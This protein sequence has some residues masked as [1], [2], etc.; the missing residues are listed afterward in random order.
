MLCAELVPEET[1]DGITPL[2]LNREIAEVT[3]WNSHAADTT[4][5]EELWLGRSLGL[6][7]TGSDYSAGIWDG[8]PI[9]ETHDE[10]GER[11]VLQAD[12]LATLQQDPDAYSDH[13]T[14]V[15]G[16]LGAAGIDPA[17]TG[18][19]QGV[20]I[21]SF[22]YEDS[23]TEL[24]SYASTL[25]VS[26]HSY[27][28]VE[29]WH[30]WARLINDPY[31]PDDDTVV[32]IWAENRAEHNED[33]DFGKYNQAVSAEVDS[34]LSTN[35]G[36]LAVWSAGNDRDDTRFASQEL[37]DEWEGQGL[38][39]DP[40]HYAAYFTGY[41]GLVLI[42][43][44]H[45]VY[46]A[47][48]ADGA[49][50]DGYDTLGTWAT[51]KNN[52]VV[53]AV[54]DTLNDPYYTN[55]VNMSDFS[56]W[57]AT[58][59]GRIKCDVVANGVALHS[60]VAE[61]DSAYDGD[62]GIGDEHEWSGTSM[63]A[64]N[65]TGTAAL[66]IEH[67]EDL[68]GDRPL[69]ATT[70]GLLL[71]T[72]FDAGNTGPDYS[73]GWGLVDAAAAANLLTDAAGDAPSSW[74]AESTYAGTTYDW[75]L[76]SDGSGPLKATICWTDPAGD[77]QGS[78][79]DDTTSVLVNDLDLWLTGPDSTTYYPWTLDPANP[80]DAAVRTTGNHLDNVEQVLI[81]SPTAGTYTIHVGGTLDGS[82]E[83]QAYSLLVGGATE[84]INGSGG[85]DTMTLIRDSLDPDLAQ[86]S[87]TGGAT[88]SIQLPS[89]SLLYVNGLAGNDTLTVD[90]GNGD[91]LPSGG[92]DYDGGAGSDTLRIDGSASADTVSCTT[93]Q[94]TVNSSDIDHTAVESLVLALGGG[95]NAVEVE[96]GFGVEDLTILGGGSGTYTFEADDPDDTENL[97]L[98]VEADAEVTIETSLRLEAL[99]LN[100]ASL[101]TIKA[102]EDP[103]QTSR[104][105]KTN[106]L[107]IAEDQG[108]PT[109]TLDLT[110]N[111]LIVDYEEEGDNPFENIEDWIRSGL[112]LSDPLPWWDGTGITSSEAR[113][114]LQ[115]TTGLGV[116]DND[117]DEWAIGDLEDLE[118]EPVDETSILVKYTYTGD[119]N[120]DGIINSHDYDRIDSNWL[121]W[122]Y[123]GIVPD[124][125]WRWAVGDFNYDD[126]I[127]SHD[128]DLIDRAWL[129][130]QGDPETRL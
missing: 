55:D 46:P 51:A 9:R 105:I 108:D 122:K 22:D 28:S 112:N 84:A 119:A 74:V 1:F 129:I 52:L 123:H 58:D 48:D 109:A 118:G 88:Y 27:G 25:A 107:S 83:E 8:G 57:G 80:A 121:N 65:V 38:T 103:Y 20:S 113:D 130:T 126:S 35:P 72:A 85:N 29:G 10:F 45:P 104:F 67:Y 75:T 111:N 6:N 30:G 71:H 76:I 14:H 40:T 79:L 117:D 116:I 64:P 82:Y 115:L 92:L 53:G 16:T 120:L 2:L 32:P 91:P 7:L 78:G 99:T 12:V 102:L 31:D 86:L 63:A 23:L 17:A 11:V 24:A 89:L 128:Y 98:T 62:P 106:S 34:V 56:S 87:I 37:I 68:F 97:E 60:S 39:W 125:G 77:A 26:N 43:V 33:P 61:S 50:D 94:A 19:A 15:A 70:K 36:H 47:P 81:D 101:V 110:N 4:N 49:I 5:T 100:D 69:A 42:P 18:M 59:D 95:A 90:F 41:P 127:S 3:L 13:A 96:G 21:L 54:A 44:G 93:T 114:N 124:G 73:Y 66:L